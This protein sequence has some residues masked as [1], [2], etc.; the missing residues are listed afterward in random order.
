MIQVDFLSISS[1][2]VFYGIYGVML[3]LSLLV[4]LC[5]SYVVK[6]FICTLSRNSPFVLPA[7]VDISMLA[8]ATLGLKFLIGLLVWM[9]C[10]SSLIF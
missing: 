7:L 10:W 3:G 6:H 2:L 5:G 1:T 4:M 8:D 9:L